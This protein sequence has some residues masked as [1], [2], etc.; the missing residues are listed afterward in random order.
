M[1][2]E[3]SKYAS[4]Q[5][6]VATVGRTPLMSEILADTRPRLVAAAAAHAAFNPALTL[7]DST[8]A[9]WEAG[10]TVIAN[11][12]ATL[13]ARTLAFTEKLDSL[14]HKPDADT[15]SLIETWDVTIRSVVAYQG[16]TYMLLLPNGRETLTAGTY[17]ARL[18][19]GR[20]FAIRLS[21]QVGKATLIALGGTVADFYTDARALRTTQN[22]AKT[23]LEDARLN[24]E[25]RRQGS[26]AALLNMVGVGLQVWK[27][28][29]ELVDSLFDVALLRGVTQAIPTAP[30]TTTW[31]PATRRLSTAALP[32]DATRLEAWRQGSGGMPEQLAIGAVGSLEVT[33]PAG[34]T[35]EAGHTYQLWLQAR[36]GTGSSGP[37]PKQSWT[38][39]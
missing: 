31:T 13:P 4:N 12:E 34:I 23:G 20:D 39:P 18:D 33:V 25:P 29:P 16:T 32:N 2:T 3:P 10:E 1:P 37:G 24:Q 15:N 6:D 5:F 11:A 27:D 35:F 19:A 17:D 38:A 30:T 28:T 14:T 7:F 9:A 22:T 8:T 26:A 36:N 21:Q